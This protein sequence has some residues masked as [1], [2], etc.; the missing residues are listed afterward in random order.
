[1]AAARLTPKTAASV[2]ASCAGRRPARPARRCCSQGKALT[3]RRIGRSG[4]KP[5]CVNGRTKSGGFLALGAVS[6]QK[7]Q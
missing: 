3:A 2:C 7:R 5:I 4:A 1:M 6:L